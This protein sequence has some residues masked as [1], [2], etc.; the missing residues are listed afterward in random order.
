LG[1]PRIS[2]NH[3]PTTR[4]STCPGWATS[5]Y[6]PPEY[7]FLQG[8]GTANDFK[9]AD[10]YGLGSL[11]AELATGHPM[12]ALAMTSWSDARRD[13]LADLKAGVTRD[14]ATLRPQFR[15]AINA[16]AEQV[17]PAIRR[18]VS[19]LLMQLC[20]PV[21]G[22]RRPQRLPGRRHPGD[23]GLLWLLRRSDILR[24]RLAVARRRT[25]YTSRATGRTA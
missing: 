3:L 20:D 14:L 8:G 4:W 16:I 25:R 15:A 23:P 10:L 21:P 18:D 2:P 22:A 12:T 19:D 11:L 24:G 13:G 7:L 17:P 5:G 6:A 9:H 1:A